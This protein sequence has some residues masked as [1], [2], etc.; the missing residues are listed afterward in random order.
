MLI[1]RRF[2]ILS[3][4]FNEI[5][6]NI[7]TILRY[8]TQEKKAFTMQAQAN[9]NNDNDNNNNNNNNNNHNKILH[10]KKTLNSNTIRKLFP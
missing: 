7:R 5:E 9:N 2:K 8:S 1:I 6:R 3:G 4:G 10:W